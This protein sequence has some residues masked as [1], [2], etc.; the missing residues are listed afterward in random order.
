MSPSYR[1]MASHWFKTLALIGCALLAGCAG[2]PRGAAPSDAG[3]SYPDWVRM[4]PVPTEESYYYVGGCS[5]AGSLDGAVEQ[6]RS[7]VAE[8]VI[9]KERAYF[10]QLFDKALK[11]S[12]TTTSSLERARFRNDGGVQYAEEVVATLEQQDLYYQRC[13]D[14]TADVCTIFVLFRLDEARS[15]EVLRRKL[16]DMRAQLRDEGN[17]AL[18]S[19]AERMEREIE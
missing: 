12:R 13:E 1:R 4:V 16:Q 14:D 18:A 15:K 3:S 19:V 8:K 9:S 10:F 7:D 17:A 5:R 2:A 6:A 11:D